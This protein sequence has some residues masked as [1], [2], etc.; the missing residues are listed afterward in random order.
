MG[1][2]I[3]KIKILLGLI[4]RSANILKLFFDHQMFRNYLIL[5]IFSDPIHF[6]TA[7]V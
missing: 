2:F 6:K 5:S 3:S 7:L 1:I 4:Y